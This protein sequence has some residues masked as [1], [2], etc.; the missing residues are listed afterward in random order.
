[1]AFQFFNPASLLPSG[2]EVQFNPVPQNDTLGVILGASM[3]NIQRAA[4]ERREFDQLISEGNSTADY[5]DT[6]SPELGAMVRKRVASYAPDPFLGYGAVDAR[7]ERANLLKGA[8]EFS[9][10]ET[11]RQANA[12][13]M[14]ASA[15]AATGLFNNY[16]AKLQAAQNAHEAALRNASQEEKD[17]SDASKAW[18]ARDLTNF[19]MTGRH[20]DSV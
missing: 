7:G 18:E 4:R 19:T 5:L 8:L 15:S 2:K 10:L 12:A 3:E 17:Y 6:V 13:R 20:L 11:E 1:M 16:P 9:K 14:A